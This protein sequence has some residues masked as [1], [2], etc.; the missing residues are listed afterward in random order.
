MWVVENS[1]AVI[2]VISEMEERPSRL[3]SARRFMSFLSRIQQEH[4]CRLESPITTP[5][6]FSTGADFALHLL[7]G[8]YVIYRVLPDCNA[9]TGSVRFLEVDQLHGIPTH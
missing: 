3:G 4:P 1:D 5:V 9:E 2:N 7:A 6:R 8:W